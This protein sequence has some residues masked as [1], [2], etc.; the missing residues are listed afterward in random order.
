[1]AFL[2]FVFN[3]YQRLAAHTAGSGGE[4]E[5]RLMAAAPGLTRETGGFSDLMNKH[6]VH[7]HSEI[8][9]DG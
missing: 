4:S 5:W 7:A 3:E 6:T 8:N 9:G 2:H 1:M